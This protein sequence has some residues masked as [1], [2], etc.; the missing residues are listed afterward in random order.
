MIEATR[1]AAKLLASEGSKDFAAVLLHVLAEV[2]EVLA[3]PKALDKVSVEARERRIFVLA[4][5]PAGL[6][7][8]FARDLINQ[9]NA[10]LCTCRIEHLLHDKRGLRRVQRRSLVGA[11]HHL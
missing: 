2:G 3:A 1:S 5:S 4:H 7:V 8:A 6:W 11:L 9:V 10:S